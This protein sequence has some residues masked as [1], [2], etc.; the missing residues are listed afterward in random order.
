MKVKFLF[1]LKNIVNLIVKTIKAFNPGICKIFPEGQIN[2]L[3]IFVWS[4]S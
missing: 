3:A 4:L 2:P 1:K